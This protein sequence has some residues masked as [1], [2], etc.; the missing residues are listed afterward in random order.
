MV[1]QWENFQKIPNKQKIDI[2]LKTLLKEMPLPQVYM[3]LNFGMDHLQ[4]YIIDDPGL[5]L[6]YHIL[7]QQIWSKLLIMLQ[8]N[9][10][11]SI[12]NTVGPLV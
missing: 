12:Y 4:I 10:Q 7:R 3:I 2:F 1:I 5:T 9:S 8:T 11:V 6:T